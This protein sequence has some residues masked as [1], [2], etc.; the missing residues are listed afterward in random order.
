MSGGLVVFSLRTFFFV[1]WVEITEGVANSQ[2]SS[3]NS[4]CALVGG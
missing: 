1:V 2:G 4:G 3:R